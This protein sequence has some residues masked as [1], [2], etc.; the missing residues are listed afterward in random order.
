MATRTK[1]YDLDRLVDVAL[2]TFE[3]RG[4][5]ATSI[6]DLSR[7]TGLA[8]SSLY[9]HI[10]GKE[11]L[12]RL[13]CARALDA[14]FAVLDDP[15]VAAGAPGERLRALVRRTAEVTVRHHRAVALLLRVRGN[16]RV[17][18]GVLARRRA[19]DRA[20]AELVAE[21]ARSGE[22]RPGL[23]PLVTARLI[24]G[25]AN[26]V[27]E[28]YRPSGALSPEDVGRLVES[29]AFEGIGARGA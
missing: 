21:A 16:G 14:L 19:F 11:D 10:D 29:M 12:L 18:H 24:F 3:R 26:S 23:D 9:H 8:R 25:M 17:E 15:E 4:Y 5:D 27:T 6:D 1:A 22:V 28:W 7:A 20:A 13:G 2:R